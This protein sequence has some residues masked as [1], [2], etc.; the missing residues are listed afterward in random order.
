MQE[1]KSKKELRRSISEEKE[2]RKINN[3]I[4]NLSGKLRRY[5]YREE[6]IEATALGNIIA[7]YETYPEVQYGMNFKIYWSR[8]R[9]FMPEEIKNEMDSRSAKADFIVYTTFI[10]LIFL[11]IVT[12][13]AYAFFGLFFATIISVFW[14]I[15]TYNILYKLS[16]NAHDNYSGYIKSVFDIYRID[17]AGKLG[18]PLSIC[19]NDDERGIWNEYSIFLEDYDDP[20]TEL[21]HHHK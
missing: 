12:V 14:I 15:I 4:R 21:F 18:L 9:F 5:P 3:Q 20:T 19:P 7:E 11:P 16:I 8:L 17:I 2:L 1:I 13:S 10:F 6:S